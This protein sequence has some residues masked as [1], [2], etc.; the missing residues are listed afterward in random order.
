MALAL[1]PDLDLDLVEAMAAMDSSETE[2]VKVL[3]DMEEATVERQRKK[4]GTETEALTPTASRVGLVLWE[5]GS[6]FGFL[7]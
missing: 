1:A 3:G 7:P 2:V 4:F 6:D 5:L